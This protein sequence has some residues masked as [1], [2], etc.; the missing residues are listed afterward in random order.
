[1]DIIANSTQI[2]KE[3]QR[4]TQPWLWFVLLSLTCLTIYVTTNLEWR[5]KIQDGKPLG[6]GHTGSLIGVLI[7]VSVLILFLTTHLRTQ[8]DKSGIGVMFFPL[9]LKSKVF[10]WDDIESLY[11]REYKALEEFGGWGIRLGVGEKYAYNVKGNVG[12]QLIFKSGKKVMIGTNNPYNLDI[13]LRDELKLSNYSNK[14][15]LE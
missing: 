10:I 8:I 1:M 2:Y 12:L 3:K 11:L 13:F 4:F 9:M 15:I 5:L 6:D 14:L 7:S